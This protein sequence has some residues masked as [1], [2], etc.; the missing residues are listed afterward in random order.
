M[1]LLAWEDTQKNE[2]SRCQGAGPSLGL[3]LLGLQRPQ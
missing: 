2:G 1:G 3:Y